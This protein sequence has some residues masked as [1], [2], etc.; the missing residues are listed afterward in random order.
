MRQLGILALA[1]LNTISWLCLLDHNILLFLGT[2][3]TPCTLFH[4]ALSR[5]T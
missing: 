4:I 2:L 5:K 1:D 3:T